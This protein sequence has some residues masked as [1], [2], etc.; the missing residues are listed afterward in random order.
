MRTSSITPRLLGVAALLG[1]IGCQ[2]PADAARWV[3]V[4]IHHRD[5][6]ERLPTYRHD[7]KLYVAGRPGERYG[8]EVRNK[9]GGRVL[10]VISLGDMVKETIS[11]QAFQIQQLERYIAS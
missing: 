11:D 4:T 9:D 7:G 10:T 2:T 5:T 8:I 1:L 3:D 6:G